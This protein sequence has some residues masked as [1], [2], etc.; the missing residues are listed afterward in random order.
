MSRKRVTEI[1]PWLLPLRQKQRRF[2]FYLKM[3]LDKNNYAIGISESLLP[4]IVFKTRT[5]LINPNTNMDLVFQENKIHN[6]RL[7]AQKLDHLL[8]KPGQTFSFW[9]LAKNAD[10]S[11]PYKDGLCL[12]NNELVAVYGGGLCQLSNMLYWLFCH[13]GLLIT[14]RHS[15]EAKHFPAPEGDMPEEADATVYEGWLDLKARNDTMSDFQILINF[16][17]NYMY[18]E[19]RKGADPDEK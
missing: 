15:H 13:S 10:K 1:F 5:K 6:L 4:M 3:F 8:I 18:G 19:L 17:E 7:V 9:R 2:C 16:D 11:T 14:E 12:V